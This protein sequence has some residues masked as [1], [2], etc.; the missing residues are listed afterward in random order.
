MKKPFVWLLCICLAFPLLN[1]SCKKKDIIE[2]SRVY[3]TY[4]VGYAGGLNGSSDQC[5]SGDGV[6]DFDVRSADW[7]PTGG[8]L[9]EGQGFGYLTLT[10][11]LKLR[12]VIYMPFL[13][14][15]TYKEH[16]ADGVAS[17]PAPWKLALGLTA[18]LGIVDGYTVSMGDYTIGLGVEDGYDVLIITF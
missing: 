1:N 18:G 10:T 17:L 8:A 12:M 7:R 13:A 2:S 4:G 11:D 3:F 5:I 14:T 16:Y 6:C 15:N 9:P